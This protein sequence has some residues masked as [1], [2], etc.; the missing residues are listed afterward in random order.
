MERIR[1]DLRHVWEQE[2][3]Q[4]VFELEVTYWRP[5]GQILSRPGMGIFVV[6]EGLV[7]EQRLFVDN[8][9]VYAGLA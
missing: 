4:L 5:D 3:D 7:H 8:A 9:A 6:R 2:D 1:H